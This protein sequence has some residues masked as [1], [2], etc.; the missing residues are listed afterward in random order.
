M[1][2]VYVVI[3]ASMHLLNIQLR[4]EICSN[5]TKMSIK[6]FCS[7]LLLLKPKIEL[8]TTKNVN[9]MTVIVA[10][11]FMRNYLAGY[12][13]RRSGMKQSMHLRRK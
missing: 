5:I 13:A 6:R 4:T 11:D 3:R 12:H 9:N 8:S 1:I 2:V 7:V 10:M